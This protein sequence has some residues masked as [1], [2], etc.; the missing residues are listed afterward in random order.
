MK[1][2]PRYYP[3]IL[4][5]T[6]TLFA[7]LGILLGFSPRQGGEGSRESG[8]LLTHHALIALNSIL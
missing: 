2:H 5:V 3:I 7:L 1:I 4:L 8:L 6:Y